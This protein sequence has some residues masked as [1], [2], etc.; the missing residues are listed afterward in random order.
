MIGVARFIFNENVE[1][2]IIP[3]DVITLQP[4]FGHKN[5]SQLIVLYAG[6]RLITAILKNILT[7]VEPYLCTG[8]DTH[9]HTVSQ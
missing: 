7:T 5:L 3:L 4:I 9:H 6:S 8:T 2:A 1:A